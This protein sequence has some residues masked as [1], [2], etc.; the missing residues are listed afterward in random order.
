M[1]RSNSNSRQ[2]ARKPG[3]SAG[4][5]VSKITYLST[6]KENFNQLHALNNLELVHTHRTAEFR[7]S[8]PKFSET[9][10]AEQEQRQL[11]MQEKKVELTVNVTRE[12]YVHISADIK[13][14]FAPSAGQA[15]WAKFIDE[16]RI[17]L[18]M[19]N[20]DKIYGKYD[21][22]PLHRILSLKQGG[23]YVARFPSDLLQTFNIIIRTD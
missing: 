8:L 13:I 7:D 16:I 21:G 17:K 5:H 6:V 19:E 3:S 15:M 11:R 22:A 12:D 23:Y 2:S 1:Q 20:V 10:D 18:G 4:P 14:E 9:Y